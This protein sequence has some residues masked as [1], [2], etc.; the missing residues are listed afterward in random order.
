MED[1]LS[2]L[3]NLG[4]SKNLAEKALDTARALGATGPSKTSCARA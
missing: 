4:Y 3:I 2:A 1:A